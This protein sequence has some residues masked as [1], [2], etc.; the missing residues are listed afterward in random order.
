[1]V[2]DILLL[3]DISDLRMWKGDASLVSALP[4]HRRIC[5]LILALLL[6]LF[7]EIELQF[8]LHPRLSEQIAVII[9][10]HQSRE[11]E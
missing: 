10:L 1:M 8:L 4:E 7:A 2:N 5:L 11:L 6:Y 3:H 9:R